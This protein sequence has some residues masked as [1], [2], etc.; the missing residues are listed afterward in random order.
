M[1]SG[2][3]SI[4]EYKHNDLIRCLILSKE[5]DVLFSG[6]DDCIIAQ[7]STKTLKPIGQ[8]LKVDIGWLF[9]I[10][11]NSNL[12]VVGGLAK[13]RIIKLKK[14]TNSGNVHTNEYNIKL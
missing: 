14:L 8:Q 11:L 7:H 10:D 3:V 6:G 9:G 12:L 1:Q 13:F 5:E 2:K 4:F